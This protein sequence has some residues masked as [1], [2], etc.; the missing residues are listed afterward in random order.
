MKP[1]EAGFESFICDWLTGD[2][3]GWRMVSWPGTTDRRVV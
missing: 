3:D 2:G 1:N